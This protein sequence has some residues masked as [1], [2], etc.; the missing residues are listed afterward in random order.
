MIQIPACHAFLNMLEYKVIGVDAHGCKE[1]AR[2]SLNQER[3]CST[4]E[5]GGKII[6]QHLF[7]FFF[8]NQRTPVLLNLS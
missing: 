2:C 8:L 6:P 1:Q 3:K 5:S 4:C 7:F